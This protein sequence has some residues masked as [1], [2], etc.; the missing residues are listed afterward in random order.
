MGIRFPEYGNSKLCLKKKKTKK[1][2][3]NL[4]FQ[5]KFFRDQSVSGNSGPPRVV[6]PQPNPWP[7]SYGCSGTPFQAG[8]VAKLKKN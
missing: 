1:T 3:K 8:V 7:A 6:Q 5:Q 4:H 2:Q